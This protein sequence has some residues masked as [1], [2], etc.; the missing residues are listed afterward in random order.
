MGFKCVGSEEE[1]ACSVIWVN[2]TLVV[3][4][5]NRKPLCPCSSWRQG[6]PFL[7]GKVKS[8]RADHGVGVRQL[9]E[10]LALLQWAVRCLRPSIRAFLKVGHLYMPYREVVGLA[11]PEVTDDHVLVQLHAF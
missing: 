5:R 1:A 10:R 8:S 2:V 4:E 3:D 6:R 9:Q 7:F 11:A